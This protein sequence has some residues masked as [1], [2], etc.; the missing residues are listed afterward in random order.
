[1]W[2]P[3]VWDLIR[4]HYPD[5][6]RDI[7]RFGEDPPGFRDHLRSQG[8]ESCVLLA[9]DSNRTGLVPNDYILEFARACP[10]FFIPFM[11]LN[12]NKTESVGKDP[13]RFADSV[14]FCCEQMEWL[15]E[16]GFRGIKDYGSYNYI[17]FGSGA[18]LPFYR[19]AVGLGLPV[20]FHTGVSMFDSERSRALGNPAGLG[21]LA[22]AVPELTIVVGHCGSGA[23]FPVAYELAKRY[24]NVYIEFSGVPPARVEHHFFEQGLDLNLIPE[25]LVFGSD[26]PALPNGSHGIGKNI[27]TYR[28]LSRNGKLSR[29]SCRGLL[30]ENACRL[31]DIP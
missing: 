8:V 25:K 18:M 6:Y 22:E 30:G 1:M 16:K 7:R 2:T 21:V 12:P 3:E 31:L 23:Y 5:N 14:R 9:E 11:A 20:L 27:R 24:P 28:E 15:A 10:E 4:A 13:G 29:E 17:P 26:Y 19:T